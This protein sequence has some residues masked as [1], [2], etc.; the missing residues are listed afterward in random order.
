M[1]FII[2]ALNKFLVLKKYV[3]LSCGQFIFDTGHS[4][5]FILPLLGLQSLEKKGQFLEASV[6]LH[7]PFPL[8]GRSSLYY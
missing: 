7:T 5:P 1:L 4:H 8:A 3:P 6:H 2:L